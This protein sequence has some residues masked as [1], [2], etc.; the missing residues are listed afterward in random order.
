M[1][2]FRWRQDYFLA[3]SK[4]VLEDLQLRALLPRLLARIVLRSTYTESS[5][6]RG[7]N[8]RDSAIR[9]LT[10]AR[11]TSVIAAATFQGTVQIWNWQAGERVSEFDT[12]TD[13][14]THLSLSPDGNYLVAANWRAGKRGGV[15][16]YRTSTGEKQWHREDIRRAGRVAFA[17]DGNSV[18]CAVNGSSLQI[19]DAQAGKTQNSMRAVQE[20]FDSPY[21]NHR[22]VIRQK[23]TLIVGSKNIEIPRLSFAVLDATFSPTALCLSEARGIVRCIDSNFGEELW[24]YEPP[25]SSHVIFISYSRS[26][27][28]FYG[29]QWDFD[30]GG[31][32]RLI[33]IPEETGKPENVCHLNAYPDSCCFG[34]GVV[35][36]SSGQV[37]CLET[38]NILRRMAF[39]ECDYPDNFPADESP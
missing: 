7:N 34:D 12:V 2:R 23:R 25:E 14:H 26:D 29:T 4:G 28:S 21:S 37:V 33:R 27:H 17:S 1:I 35:V 30:S 32:H 19:L 31:P 18:W 9:S 39:P 13:G 11:E 5:A 8:M 15:A 22:L 38:G 20:V 24:R 16:C 6:R 3:E 36:T 10:A